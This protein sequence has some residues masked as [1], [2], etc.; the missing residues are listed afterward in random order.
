MGTV[1][2]DAVLRCRPPSDVVLTAHDNTHQIFINWPLCCRIETAA[3]AGG[4]MWTES[5]VIIPPPTLDRLESCTVLESANIPIDLKHLRKIMDSDGIAFDMT[6]CDQGLSRNKIPLFVLEIAMHSKDGVTRESAW[7]LKSL[8]VEL[9]QA[10]E[11][12]TDMVRSR[13]HDPVQMSLSLRRERAALLSRP[14]DNL[15]VM[16]VQLVLDG[17]D[18]RGRLQLKGDLGPDGS[19]VSMS[20]ALVSHVSDSVRGVRVRWGR[21]GGRPTERTCHSRF[22]AK[23]LHSILKALPP[24]RGPAPS[25][26]RMASPA[27]L[28]T[29]ESAADR[30]AA[31]YA[32]GGLVTLS[33]FKNGGPLRVQCVIG[34]IGEMSVIICP[35]LGDPTDQSTVLDVGPPPLAELRQLDRQVKRAGISA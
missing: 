4:D 14:M 31:A 17:Q 19:W 25:A 16:C 21:P 23:L 1:V 12:F 7:Q 26:L 34:A 8:G 5:A 9:T 29:P 10:D 6:I 35:H 30:K 28:A 20:N 24:H 3:A 27:P 32:S 13:I 15:G 22:Q 11:D 33:L 2:E 18:A